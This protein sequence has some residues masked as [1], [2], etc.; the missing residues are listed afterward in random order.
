MPWMEKAWPQYRVPRP[1]SRD[2]GHTC[3]APA[4]MPANVFEVAKPKSLWQ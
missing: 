2:G 1:L 4:W 3:L